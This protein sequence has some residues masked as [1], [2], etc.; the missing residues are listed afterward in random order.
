MKRSLTDKLLLAVMMPFLIN[1]LS[2]CAHNQ[3]MSSRHPVEVGRTQLCSHCHSDWRATLNHS[4]EYSRRHK[5]HA[6]QQDRTCTLC[7]S[8]SFCSDCHAH[9]EEI[10]PSDKY[11]EYVTRDMP[12]RGDY[13][14][15]HQIDGRIYPASCFKCHGRQN[16]ERCRI[17]H[18]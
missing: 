16:N 18:R 10:K 17:C 7:H 13:L 8:R 1:L 12:H 15:Q 6:Y 4:P 2:A 11:K 9:R 5:F 14:S 3:S